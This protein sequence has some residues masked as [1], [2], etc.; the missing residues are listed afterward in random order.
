[1]QTLSTSSK[2]LNGHI[3]IEFIDKRT[4]IIGFV[5][6]IY[7]SSNHITLN[8]MADNRIPVQFCPPN[9]NT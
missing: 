4:K 7:K 9:N 6:Y 2:K 3:I 1:M 5:E 8:T